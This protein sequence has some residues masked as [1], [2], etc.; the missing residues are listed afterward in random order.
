MYWDYDKRKLY[1]HDT[2]IMLKPKEKTVLALLASNVN[3]TVS[4]ID[5]F[6][7]IYEDQPHRDFSSDAITSLIKRI[8]QKI[9][10][11]LFGPVMV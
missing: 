1:W 4:S 6:N 7:H 8:R 5:I 10:R 11:I 3:A 9:P 2:E